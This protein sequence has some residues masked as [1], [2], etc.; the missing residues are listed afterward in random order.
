MSHENNWLQS[1]QRLCRVNFVN[2]ATSKGTGIR[3]ITFFDVSNWTD[4]EIYKSKGAADGAVFLFRP[5]TEEN[6]DPTSLFVD[7]EKFALGFRHVIDQVCYRYKWKS[8]TPSR[9]SMANM[10]MGSNNIFCNYL[11]LPAK[12]PLLYILKHLMLLSKKAGLASQDYCFLNVWDMIGLLTGFENFVDEVPIYATLLT[13]IVLYNVSQEMKAMRENSKTANDPAVQQLASTTREEAATNSLTYTTTL[14]F[15]S[16]VAQDVIDEGLFEASLKQIDASPDNVAE[17]QSLSLSQNKDQA[18]EER[19][20]SFVPDGNEPN[21]NLP[22]I[23]STPFQ[24]MKKEYPSRSLPSA[25][26]D[27]QEGFSKGKKNY[28]NALMVEDIWPS[29][30]RENWMDQ[31]TEFKMSFAEWVYLLRLGLL[32]YIKQ[33]ASDL[34]DSILNNL[35]YGDIQEEEIQ[36]DPI[37]K[38]DF[39]K[40]E[41]MARF[42][43]MLYANKIRGQIL[44]TMLLLPQRGQICNELPWKFM[45]KAGE[46]MESPGTAN[47]SQSPNVINNKKANIDHD[48]QGTSASVE[49][50]NVN[51]DSQ[52][53]SAGQ[54]RKDSETPNQT[55]MFSTPGPK[56]TSQTSRKADI[57]DC[58]HMLMQ[59][60]IKDML[61]RTDVKWC[62]A[63]AR[64]LEPNL[65]FPICDPDNKPRRSSVLGAFEELQRVPSSPPQT[66][67]NQMVPSGIQEVIDCLKEAGSM[68]TEPGQYKC[69]VD[70]E[71]RKGWS[72]KIITAASEEE[73]PEVLVINLNSLDRKNTRQLQAVL[74]WAAAS[75]L[76]IPMIHFREAD[77]EV[78]AQLPLV[79][80]KVAEKE[81]K[82]GTLL[83]AI[84]RYWMNQLILR[85]QNVTPRP[86]LD[87][88]L[89]NL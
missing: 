38:C 27:Q 73:T 47:S 46:K 69:S 34:V 67:A 12:K 21:E 52:M 85:Q 74:Q 28:V 5:A 24:A 37:I 19:I 63:I 51:L 78:L 45:T 72:I 13:S 82:V 64:E 20:Q 4:E 39:D 71:A 35:A 55:G 6:L 22:Q 60:F 18:T 61:N 40:E 53:P 32:E 11:N 81:I 43:L 57:L 88:L 89:E 14:Q 26:K 87:W 56:L 25:L 62:Q 84:L 36:E 16:Q 48:S 49:N 59:H 65:F 77:A 15:A 30:M 2:P 10:F 75:Q 83:Q 8:S 9:D 1:P 31:G 29:P 70:T 68:C 86:V 66:L 7:L 79:M 33:F 76:N 58:V 44:R 3:A 54:P 41:D 50:T 23:P 80:K 17:L 42:F